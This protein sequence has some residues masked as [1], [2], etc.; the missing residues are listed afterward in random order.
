MIRRKILPFFLCFCATSVFSFGGGANDSAVVS[1]QRLAT[2]VGVYIM[3]S[4]G[5]AVDAAVAMGY[6]LAVVHPSSGNIGGGGF[7]LVYWQGK[8]IVID[9]REKAPQNLTQAKINNA[10][11]VLKDALSVGVPGT[12]AGLNK[13][14][15]M[16]AKLPLSFDM[17][18]AIVLAEKGF[19]L[20]KPDL[21]FIGQGYKHNKFNNSS[22]VNFLPHGKELIVGDVLKQP[23][24]ANTLQQIASSGDRAFYNGNFA[25]SL[26]AYVDKKGGV[27][28]LRDMQSYHAIVQS[29]LVCNYKG[30]VIYTASPPSRGGFVLCEILQSVSHV[31]S[32]QGFYQPVWLRANIEAMRKADTL[33]KYKISDPKYMQQTAQSILQSTARNYATQN[34]TEANLQRREGFNTTSF[35][36]KDSLGN[37]VAMIYS[38]NGYFGSGMMAPDSGVFLNDQINDFYMPKSG[39][40]VAIPGVV[41]GGAVPVSSMAPTMLLRNGQLIFVAGTPGGDTIPTQLALL[42]E[43]LVSFNEK[44]AYAVNKP[45]YHM[46]SDG[47]LYVEKNAPEDLKLQLKSL[48][49]PTKEGSIY[50]Y[51]VWGGMTALWR[52]KNGKWDAVVDFRR[53]GG[54]AKV[55]RD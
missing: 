22:S 38:L 1:E 52:Q 26:V 33:A 28:S 4:G 9:F 51:D 42:I 29:P 25:R 8:P 44:L 45:R 3:K 17:Q 7:M 39:N 43:S 14:H 30:D 34:Y 32:P 11:G 21:F 13:A 54:M 47:T 55:F 36:T 19:R 53:P 16:F 18:P 15:A 2:D 20:T 50:G 35:V 10:Q 41:R 40:K 31:K 48:G 24:L 23:Q 37:A 46:N 5:N 49:Y 6:A 27:L 12:V